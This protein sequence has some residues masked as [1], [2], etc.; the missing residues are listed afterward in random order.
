VLCEK[1]L[2][3]K[4]KA[5]QSAQD[6]HDSCREVERAFYSNDV[7]IQA[8]QDIQVKCTAA[9][10]SVYSTEILF[11]DFELYEPSKYWSAEQTLLFLY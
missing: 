3:L 9:G 10:M 2:H 11:F 8:L 7:L 4:D 6:I 1:T 5:E